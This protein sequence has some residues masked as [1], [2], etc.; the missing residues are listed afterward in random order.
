[1]Q[2]ARQLKSKKMRVI[3]GAVAILSQLVETSPE[4]LKN[5]MGETLPLLCRL[6]SDSSTTIP[7]TVR[8]DVLSFFSRLIKQ[9]SDEQ[10]QNYAT[11]ILP[12]IETSINDSFYK[13]VAEG[14]R[15][16]YI[17]TY[18][19]IYIFKDLEFK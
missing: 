16:R 13:I 2:I 14:L 11:A 10:A 4:I 18:K 9:V 6:V 15:Q 17:L 12:A 3:Q 8:L 5:P 7:P 1:M 19:L